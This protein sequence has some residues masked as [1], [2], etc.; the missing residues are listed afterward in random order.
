MPI[1]RTALTDVKNPPFVG[2]ACIAC[3]VEVRGLGAVAHNLLG[4]LDRGEWDRVARKKEELREALA[5]LRPH[6]HAHFAD[7]AHSHGH[8]RK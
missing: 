4:A 7:P 6:V 8:V 1:E 2:D 5:A 3:P